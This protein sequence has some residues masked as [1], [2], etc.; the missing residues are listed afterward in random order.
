MVAAM[1]VR[2]RCPGGVQQLRQQAWM[3]QKSLDKVY[4]GK[5][6]SGQK[7]LRLSDQGICMVLNVHTPYGL[8]ILGKSLT[9]K[10]EVPAAR[11]RKRCQV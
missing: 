8:K 2:A 10:T 11:P 9:L 3:P 1:A 5:E 4:R 6:R 7:L